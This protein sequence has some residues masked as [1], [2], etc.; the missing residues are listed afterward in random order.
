MIAENTV[1]ILGAGASCPYGFPSGRKLVFDICK[2]L[3]SPG[4][5][6][7]NIITSF[8][9]DTTELNVFVKELL[10]SH[11]SID[12]FLEEHPNFA[13]IGKVSIALALIPFEQY[14]SLIRKENIEWYEHLC[15][16]MGP[17]REKFLLN[18]KN[19]SFITFNY[20]R[21]LDFYLYNT[22]TDSYGSEFALKI[23]KEIH[24]VHAY[25]QLGLPSFFDSKGRDYPGKNSR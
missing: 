22:L 16:Q 18:A 23:L 6:Q 3:S 15:H 11:L 25:G 4:T 8:V 7:F 1:F 17:S 21:S 19:L 5:Y 12:A 24:F 2:I 10:G 20:D 13:E 14:S 9:K